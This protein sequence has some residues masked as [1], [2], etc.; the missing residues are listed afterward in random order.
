[1]DAA[2]AASAGAQREGQGS[3]KPFGSCKG[4]AGHAGG[5]GPVASAKEAAQE[6][7]WRRIPVQFMQEWRGFKEMLGD[8]K[9]LVRE[10][11]KRF[12]IGITRY[13]HLRYLEEHSRAGDDIELLLELPNRHAAQLFRVLRDSRSQYRQDLFVLSELDFKRNGFFVEFGA[14]NGV[15][16]SNTYL[17]EKEFG[18]DGILAEPARHW[19]ADL[20]GNRSSRIVTDCVWRDSKSTLIFNEV[21]ALSTIDSYSSSDFHSRERRHGTRYS[22]KTISLEDLLDKYGAP[23][24][25]DYLSIDTEGSEYEILSNCNLDKYRFRVITVE[26]NRGPG[27]EKIFRLLTAHGYLRKLEKFSKFDDWYVQAE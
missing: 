26:H 16:Q 3:A 25:I 6:G 27:R 5:F 13:S 17:L 12:D 23:R 8:L 18:W 1:M 14:T 7:S 22:V 19:H 10:T 11:L 4:P 24:E 2:G 15:G 20:R 21:G 9:N